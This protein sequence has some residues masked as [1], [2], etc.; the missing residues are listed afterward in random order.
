MKGLGRADRNSFFAA[1]SSK[2]RTQGHQQKLVRDRFKII[3]MRWCFTQQ[4]LKLRN[5]L[6][7]K[8]YMIE[9]LQGCRGRLDKYLEDRSIGS[10]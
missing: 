1:T 4:A 8:L 5:F 3:K 6:Q 2:R 7:R 10:Y 9:V